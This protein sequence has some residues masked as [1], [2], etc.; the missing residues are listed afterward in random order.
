VVALAV[1]AVL[2]ISYSGRDEYE[3]V[4]SGVAGVLALLIALFPMNRAVALLELAIPP[5]P[6]PSETFIEILFSDFHHIVHNTSASI[7]FSLTAALCFLFARQPD[8]RRRSQGRPNLL[9]QVSV[10]VVDGVS[11]ARSLPYVLC[12]LIVVFGL[13]LALIN[14]LVGWGIYWPEVIMLSGFCLCWLFVLIAPPPP[15]V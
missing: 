8:A 5:N 4:I 6:A 1:G 10:G 11:K 12:G 7:F 15:L 13:L 14:S 9:N 3:Y 2:L